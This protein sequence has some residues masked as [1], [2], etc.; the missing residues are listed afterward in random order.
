MHFY[1]RKILSRKSASFLFELHFSRMSRGF[2]KKFKKTGFPQKRMWKMWKRGRTTPSFS[3]FMVKNSVVFHICNCGDCGKLNL[4][5]S[6]LLLQKR[7]FSENSHFFEPRRTAPFFGAFRRSILY[8]FSSISHFGG[9]SRKAL[10]APRASF[11]QF[12]PFFAKRAHFFF[13][14]RHSYAQPH[15]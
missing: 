14:S 15:A 10:S 4:S 11:V 13:F 12:F 2:R 1:C 6:V 5:F 9:L 8:E 3:G 7:T